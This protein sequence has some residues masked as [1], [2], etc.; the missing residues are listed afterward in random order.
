[1]KTPR[2]YS[3]IKKVASGLLGTTI[4]VLSLPSGAQALFSF[5][6]QAVANDGYLAVQDFHS[7]NDGSSVSSAINQSFT[8]KNRAGAT[9]TLNFNGSSTGSS[10][11]GRLHVYAKSTL[12]NSYYNATNSKY[13]DYNGNVIDPNGSPTIF[14][15]DA[16]ATFTD[17]LQFGGSLQSGYKARYIFHI[18]GL[19]AGP[20]YGFVLAATVDGNQDITGSFDSGNVNTTWA[21]KTF[22]VNGITP[23]DIRVEL[24]NLVSFDTSALTDGVN[25]SGLADFSSTAIL[26]GIELI[27]SNGNLASGWTV[28]SASGTRYNAIQGTV[29]AV[30]EPGAIALLIG[31]TLS[32]G[33]IFVRRRRKLA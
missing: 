9:Q 16:I 1:M 29:S 33:L 22:D 12:T 10:E 30:P 28:T 25:Y 23:Q 24:D 17:T 15:S 14:S 27:D 20:R 2:T 21:T 5:A 11:Y 19:T 6:R 7:V 8:G 3:L 32:G 13:A 4:L 26:T 18:D 31:G